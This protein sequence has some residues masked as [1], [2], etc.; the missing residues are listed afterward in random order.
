MY[1][2]IDVIYF[3][4]KIKEKFWDLNSYGG[5][6]ELIGILKFVR[7]FIFLLIYICILI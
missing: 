4:I 1:F 3:N 6:L 2:C 7:S 5:L